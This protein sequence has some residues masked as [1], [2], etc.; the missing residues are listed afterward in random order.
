MDHYYPVYLAHSYLC[1]P[2]PIVLIAGDKSSSSHCT[3]LVVTLVVF[4]IVA[5]DQL[6]SDVADEHREVLD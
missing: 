6:Y 5:V 1:I 4:W 2:I 3:Y